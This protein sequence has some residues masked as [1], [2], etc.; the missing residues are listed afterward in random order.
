M[1]WRTHGAP[2]GNNQQQGAPLPTCCRLR[3]SASFSQNN[4]RQ[5]CRI[6]PPL[7]PKLV[8]LDNYAN[9][10]CVLAMAAIDPERTLALGTR[11]AAIQP[12]AD[13]AR[14]VAFITEAT[15]VPGILTHIGEPAEPPRISPAPRA[16]GPTVA[17]GE[18]STPFPP[19][20]YR[21]TAFVTSRQA[22]SGVPVAL[23]W[24]EGA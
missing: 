11:T 10:P 22:D 7:L 8:S 9:I 24:S 2:S 17:A 13:T 6:L 23:L 3:Y 21:K 18:K 14:M 5:I 20:F 4:P 19:T 15:L 1:L 16:A 12:I